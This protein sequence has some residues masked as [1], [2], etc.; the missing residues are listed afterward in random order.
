MREHEGGKNVNVVFGYTEKY[1]TKLFNVL[2]LVF[3][4]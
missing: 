4:R 1:E 2:Q 3:L